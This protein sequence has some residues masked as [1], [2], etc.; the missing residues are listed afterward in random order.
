M[1]ILAVYDG[2]S[3]SKHS[4][5]KKLTG[6]RQHSISIKLIEEECRLQ[7]ISYIIMW[8]LMSISAQNRI[9]SDKE[10]IKLN[11]SDIDK[12]NNFNVF[13]VCVVLVTITLRMSF[14]RCP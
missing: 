9:H 14:H 10:T 12:N 2:I 7:H 4:P 3:V 1:Y 13:S 11:M 8:Q 5:G 6:V